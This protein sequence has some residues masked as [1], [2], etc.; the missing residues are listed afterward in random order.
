MSI[1]HEKNGIENGSSSGNPAKPVSKRG[2]KAGSPI[3]TVDQTVY[4]N[5]AAALA[6]PVEQ[7]T[8]ELYQCTYE[9]PAE[10]KMVK[11]ALY[12]WAIT[13]NHA[14]TNF[15]KFF[16]PTADVGMVSRKE[17]S[18]WYQKAYKEVTGQQ[19]P[20]NVSPVA[21]EQPASS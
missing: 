1:G 20:A 8:A 3:I 7:E 13:L 5:R 6:N 17:V 21:Q 10:G 2:R 12:T 9:K 14:S 15:L 4:K 19:Q 16:S 11:V 18:K